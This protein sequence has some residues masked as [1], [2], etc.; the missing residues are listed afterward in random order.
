MFEN[1]NSL[2][3]KKHKFYEPFKANFEKHML[4]KSRGGGGGGRGE[5]ELGLGLGIG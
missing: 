4:V 5:K 1:L 3:S 2:I